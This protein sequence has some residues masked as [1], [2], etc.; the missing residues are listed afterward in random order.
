MVYMTLNT[1]NGVIP[2]NVVTECSKFL[3]E[4]GLLYIK[5][6]DKVG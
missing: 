2:T 5:H 3:A 1:M 4:N 6:A